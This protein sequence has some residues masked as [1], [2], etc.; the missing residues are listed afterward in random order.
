MTGDRERCLAAGM[1]DYLSK[2]VRIE[3]L[4]AVLRRIL[5]VPGGSPDGLGLDDRNEPAPTDR[6]ELSGPIDQAR[7]ARLMPLNRPGREDAVAELIC[8]FLADT[9]ARLVAL[10]EAATRDDPATLAQVAHA[11]RGAADHF[12]AHEVTALC[13][14][15]ERLARTAGIGGATELLEALDEAFGRA[16]SA[17]ETAAL[18]R[19]RATEHDA[20]NTLLE[21]GNDSH[22]ARQPE[23]ALSGKPGEAAQARPVQPA[24]ERTAYRLARMRAPRRSEYRPRARRVTGRSVTTAHGSPGQWQSSTTSG[25]HRC[26]PP[27]AVSNFQLTACISGVRRAAPGSVT[28][29]RM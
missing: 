7:L 13:D 29:C 18:A 12:G 28:G 2:S 1:D 24:L 26:A 6:R 17:L 19:H 15:L 4:E 23:T 21:V 20:A 25:P 9:P 27:S 3:E 22:S 8:E 14:Q 11:L 5:T 10:R 16:R